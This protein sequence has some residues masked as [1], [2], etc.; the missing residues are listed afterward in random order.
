MNDDADVPQIRIIIGS[1]LT[2]ALVNMLRQPELGL[3]VLTV[4]PMLCP[5]TLFDDQHER[6]LEISALDQSLLHEE[7]SS[8]EH[9][10]FDL[11]DVVFE[12]RYT[13][14]K[15]YM[16]PMSEMVRI[17]DILDLP[18]FTGS[19]VYETQNQPPVSFKPEGRPSKVSRS[20]MYGK[21]K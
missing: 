9:D 10:L 20:S 16:D 12:E 19:K 21:K 5:Y 7:L 15:M 2:P 17:D 1:C 4:E 8:A 14:S 3:E 18:R 11:F 13:A 6:G